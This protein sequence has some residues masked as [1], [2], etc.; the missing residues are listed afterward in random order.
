M[1]MRT[2]LGS[3]AVVMWLVGCGGA[4]QATEDETARDLSLAPAESIAVLDDR[5]QSAPEPEPVSSAAPRR[6]APPPAPPAPPAPLALAAGSVLALTA[7]DTVSSRTHAVGDPVTAVASADVRDEQGRVVVPA[8]ARFVGSIAEIEQAPSPGA[9]GTLRLTFTEVEFGGSRYTVAARSD[10]LGTVTAGRGG[11]ST[12]DAAKV[13]VGAAAGAI[14]GRVLGGDTKGAI[15]G[16]AVGAAAGAGVA[17]AT[18]DQ[19]VV[20][21]AG[22]Y[23]R[24]VLD[25][26]LVLTPIG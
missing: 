1:R 3:L 26:E 8:G 17:V 19:D 24:V 13:G 9:P 16:G 12:G 18:K 20:L 6:Q 23:V 10:S 15:I 2:V 11:V 22:G 7:S 25:R 5:P 14:A 4:E 21:P